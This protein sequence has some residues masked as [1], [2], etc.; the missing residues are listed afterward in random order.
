MC[1][2]TQGCACVMHVCVGDIKNVKVSVRCV[3]IDTYD[4]NEKLKLLL[5]TCRYTHS[6][7]TTCTF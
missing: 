5:K 7:Y 6:L 3:N 2:Y 1:M 4:P